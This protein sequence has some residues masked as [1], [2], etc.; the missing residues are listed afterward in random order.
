MSTI[1]ARKDKYGHHAEE[2]KKI[3]A[4][5]VKSDEGDWRRAE[6][7]KLNTELSKPLV[8]TSAEACLN[9]LETKFDKVSNMLRYSQVPWARGGSKD[10]MAQLLFLWE[11][12][13]GRVKAFLESMKKMVKT[14]KIQVEI[15]RK[16]AEKHGVV[17]QN[18][19]TNIT[20]NTVRTAVKL[21]YVEIFPRALALGNIC[22]LGEDV[23]EKEVISVA[24]PMISPVRE[25]EDITRADLFGTE[26]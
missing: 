20:W 23:A 11:K 5:V 4:M 17:L 6:I 3:G 7:A 10:N 25:R 22:W 21:M 26:D 24:M 18:D 8:V 9:S 19:I 13:N 14:Q 1:P 12:L 15:R 2:M 16:E